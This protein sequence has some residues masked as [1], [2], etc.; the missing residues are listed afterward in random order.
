MT[1]PFPRACSQDSSQSR[2]KKDIMEVG[3]QRQWSQ[4][5]QRPGMVSWVTAALC[6]TARKT[7]WIKGVSSLTSP[8]LY[9]KASKGEFLVF[10]S[11]RTP[12][13]IQLAN[14]NLNRG[15]GGF[16]NPIIFPF[17][18]LGMY[19]NTSE[20]KRPTICD[21]AYNWTELSE[22]REICLTSQSV[23]INSNTLCL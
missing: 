9:V 15:V 2:E 18:W 11:W 20:G 21:R 10:S 3:E 12:P 4:Q 13:P 6:P 1:Q 22:I 17:Q 8:C 7:A 16:F 14:K 19:L 23:G 5:I